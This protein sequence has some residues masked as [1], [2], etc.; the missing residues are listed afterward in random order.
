MPEKISFIARFI[1]FAALHSLFAAPQTKR[2]FR[3]SG[4]SGYRLGYNI[5]SLAMFGW[6]MSVHRHSTVLYVAPGVWSLVMYLMQLAVLAILVSCLKQTGIRTFLG[7]AGQKTAVFSSSGWYSVVR[8]PL[9]LFSII[10]MVLNPVM[11]SQW[12]ILTL[13]STLYF[14]I[15]GAL[16]EKRLVTEFGAAYQSYQK[17]VPFLIPGRVSAAPLPERE[18]KPL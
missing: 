12:L 14:M 3:V 7:F 5:A 8:H 9:Y 16:E 18:E 10:F 4:Q 2:M 13:M 6:V 11:T 15:G 17:R 1:L